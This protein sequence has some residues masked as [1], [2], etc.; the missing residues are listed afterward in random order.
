MSSHSSHSGGGFSL[1]RHGQKYMKTWPDEKR[2]GLVFSE[3]RVCKMTRFAI[4]YM[5][6]IAAFALTWQI[7]L[8]GDLGPA[9]ATALFACSLPL[10]GIWWLGK[11]SVTALPPHLME[12]FYS[13]REKLSETGAALAPLEKTPDYQALADLLNKAFKQLDNTFLDD[14]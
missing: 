10:Q 4:R 9:V 5:P 11:R 7:A 1:F 2:L 13:I 3:N 8:G 12:W 14:L 6:P